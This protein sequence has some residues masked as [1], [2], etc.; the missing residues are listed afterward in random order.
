MKNTILLCMILTIL[1]TGGLYSKDIG[2]GAKGG[3]NIAKKIG[4]DAEYDGI[5]PKSKLGLTAGGFVTYPINDKLTV[6]P[7]ILI[8]QK[9]AR[10]KGDTSD[11]YEYKE[12][13][14]M[15]WLD[16]PILAVFQVNDVIS[17]FAGP[18]ID[19]FLG[20]KYVWEWEGDGMSLDGD[21][22]ID[23]EDVNSLGFGLIFG[24]A[25]GVTDNIDVEGRIALGLT[26]MDEDH[27]VKNFGIQVIANYHLKKNK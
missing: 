2:Y 25:Y 13:V 10:Y 21:D 22:K 4:E 16:I 19:L 17:A 18:Y 7:E 12:K 14:K 23:G 8:T 20:G 26:S 6:R 3:L 24:G 1:F 9:G 15:T 5:S 27:S 11:G